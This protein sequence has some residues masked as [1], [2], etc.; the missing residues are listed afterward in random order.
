MMELTSTTKMTDALLEQRSERAERNR[1][2]ES[3]KMQRRRVRREKWLQ[4]IKS[5]A[6]SFATGAETVN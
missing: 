2:L 3:I 1:R 5:L 4:G 6:N